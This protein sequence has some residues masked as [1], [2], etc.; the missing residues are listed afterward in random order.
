MDESALGELRRAL[1]AAK[2][3]TFLGSDLEVLQREL[4]KDQT[5]W[6][7]EL[8]RVAHR[9]YE[10]KR[11]REAIDLFAAARNI[12][13]LTHAHQLNPSVG[14]K[15]S[16]KPYLLQHD[17]ELNSTNRE[18]LQGVDVGNALAVLANDPKSR[19]RFLVVTQ[20][21]EDRAQFANASAR[22]LGDLKEALKDG[23][24]V[25]IAFLK[26]NHFVSLW[27]DAS[28][29]RVE[30]FDSL[31]DSGPSFTAGQQRVYDSILEYLASRWNVKKVPVYEVG[32]VG[33]QRGDSEC[34]MYTIWFLTA[35]TRGATIEEIRAAQVPDTVCSKAR[36]DV[37]IQDP[38]MIDSHSDATKNVVRFSGLERRRR[39]PPRAPLSEIVELD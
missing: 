26:S 12:Y 29:R 37:F 18:W 7:S 25:G 1:E 22:I 17:P 32:S 33:K 16:F 35:K 10:D 27:I 24:N 30:Y 6:Y 28:A 20:L 15:T 4:G 39:N 11:E 9:A 13:D 5:R 36:R 38:D 31:L 21:P 34:G 2:Q 19:A 3:R 8:G 23:F 14:A